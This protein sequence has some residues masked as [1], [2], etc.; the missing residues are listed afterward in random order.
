MDPANIPESGE[1]KINEARSEDINDEIIVEELKNYCVDRSRSAEDIEIF[2]DNYE[3]S[4]N[5]QQCLQQEHKQLA[6]PTDQCL[7]SDHD[8]A[9]GYETLLG[10]T[11]HVET[12]IEEIQEQAM[13]NKHLNDLQRRYE[14]LFNQKIAL[15]V[16]RDIKCN[17]EQNLKTNTANDEVGNFQAYPKK[18][19]EKI[20]ENDDKCLKP[21]ETGFEEQRNLLKVQVEEEVKHKIL[22]LDENHCELESKYNEEKK[23]LEQESTKQ[24]SDISFSEDDE[25]LY[26]QR[27]EL[28]RQ[29]NEEGNQEFEESNLFK[30]FCLVA[31][32]RDELK[33]K[34]SDSSTEN[35]LMTQ[36]LEKK[37]SEATEE[38]RLVVQER[39]ELDEK[40]SD[41]SEENDLKAHDLETKLSK[42]TEELRLVAQERDELKE[43]LCDLSVENENLQDRNNYLNCRQQNE[44]TLLRNK[45]KRLNDNLQ[46][47]RSK[48]NQNVRELEQYRNMKENE[49]KNLKQNIENLSANMI[50]LGTHDL[51]AKLSKTT[52]E[53]RLVAQERDVLKQKLCDLSAKNDLKVRDLEAKLS[54][55]AEEFRLVA[56]K[57]DEL[58]QKLWDL[59]E[60]NDLKAHE[61]Q[62]KLSEATDKF[63]LMEQERDELKQKLCDLSEE[64]DLKV[65]DLEAKLSATAEEFRLVAQKRDELKQKLCD[66]SEENEK[67]RDRNIYLNGYNCRQ[68]N[69]ET[70]LRNKICLISDN[71][72][73]VQ[74]K[75]DENIK[76]LEQYRNL[77]ESE[78]KSLKQNIANLSANMITLGVEKGSLQSQKSEL[79]DQLSDIIIKFN[80][81]SEECQK[82]EDYKCKQDK[83]QGVLKEQIQNLREEKE[84]LREYPCQLENLN[85]QHSTLKEKLRELEE[86]SL[87]EASMLKER[88][89]SLQQEKYAIEKKFFK[90][91]QNE[92]DR[93]RKQLKLCNQRY[94]YQMMKAERSIAAAM[95]FIKMHS[96]TA[97]WS[98]PVTEIIKFLE[99]RAM[100]IVKPEDL[101]NMQTDRDFNVHLQRLEVK[102]NELKTICHLH[103]EGR[104]EKGRKKNLIK[105]EIS[106]YDSG[107]QNVSKADQIRS[108]KEQCKA[109]NKEL[110]FVKT[111]YQITRVAMQNAH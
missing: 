19:V 34:L 97:E 105:N 23:I 94:C 40:L 55:T 31:Q 62:A 47:V 104:K 76:E 54:A 102:C 5:E 111:K 51:E 98:A 60:E 9:A 7:S 72:Q 1:S 96:T 90:R 68:Q 13:K 4:P 21:G 88:F 29:L 39:N 85:R 49:V 67:L 35:D 107:D 32:E 46:E 41:L 27:S 14:D 93:Y 15:H 92:Q 101:I 52:E 70:L 50:A 59:S 58:K 61:L 103:Y 82:L 57:R 36:D 33:Q 37:L 11:N 48:V 80:F 44:E 25:N 106:D 42:I 45:I 71:L 91:L 2:L 10:V 100:Q 89:K 95:Q 65:H 30:V 26:S 56:Q 77:K 110:K 53:F 20:E 28:R 109:L 16:E 24:F 74:S 22:E 108:L 73:Q 43:K 18:N 79:K 83:E 64:N 99:A 66:L 17:E 12:L 63:R 86:K 38:F 6:I 78:V 81:M 75:L 69:Q 87:E 84:K 8:L 3:K